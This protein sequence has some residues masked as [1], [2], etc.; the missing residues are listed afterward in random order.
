MEPQRPQI[1]KTILKRKKIDK[2]YCKVMV[3][4]AA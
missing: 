3:M 1:T 4:M 2:V